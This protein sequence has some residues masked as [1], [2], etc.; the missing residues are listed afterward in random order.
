MLKTGDAMVVVFFGAGTGEWEAS[1]SSDSPPLRLYRVLL[2]RVVGDSDMDRRRFL[3]LESALGWKDTDF[4]GEGVSGVSGEMGKSVVA[5]RWGV[6]R[7][8]LGPAG[9]TFLNFEGRRREAEEAGETIGDREYQERGGGCGRFSFFTVREGG[10]S[11]HGESKGDEDRVLVLA[12]RGRASA[13]E[14]E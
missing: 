9:M 10:S 7:R 13:G 8:S 1:R 3:G 2:A 11:L 6:G 14:E 12:C 4:I 5:G